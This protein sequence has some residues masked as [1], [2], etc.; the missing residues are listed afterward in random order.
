VRDQSPDSPGALLA[1]ERSHAELSALYGALAAAIGEAWCVIEVIFESGRP[2]DYLFIDVNAAFEQQTGLVDPVGRRM[3]ELAATHE[4]HWFEIYGNVVTS[5]QPARVTQY[6][7]ALQRWF[8]VRAFRAGAAEDRRV[9]VVFTDVTARKNAEAA[10]EVELSGARALQRISTK[11]I[12]EQRSDT[13][14]AGILDAGIELMRAD[15]AAIRIFDPVA[16]T[17]KL[18]AGR[19]LHPDSARRLGSVDAGPDTLAG[20]ALAANRRIVVADV[21]QDARV[22]AAGVLAEYQRSGLRS[23]QA[24][25]LI[26]RSGR[27]LGM[28]S[29]Y[30]SRV[31]APSEHEL[32]LFDVLA[33][34]VSDLLERTQAEAALRE[35]EERFRRLVHA[36]SQAVWEADADGVVIADSPSWRAYT[37]QSLEDWLGFGWLDAIH[38]DDR[39]FVEAQWRAAVAERRE[40]DLAFRLRRAD[41]EWRWTNLRAA[42]LNAPGGGVQKWVGMNIDVHARRQA[43]ADLVESDL[44]LRLAL[45][46]AEMGT[47]VWYPQDDVCEGDARMMALFGL[48]PDGEINLR[49]ALAK[50]IHVDD[51]ERYAEAV[52]RATDP[53]GDG[54]LKEDIRVLLGDG[55]VRWLAVKGRVQFGG[56]PRQALRMGGAAIDITHRKHVEA[57]LRD[58][59]ARLASALAATRVDV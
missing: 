37:G 54:V 15:A 44:R 55:G 32:G 57:A 24:T 49:L 53:G 52:L 48:P 43:E 6:A 36:T 35:S 9:A 4:A 5:G 2:V 27:A 1:G 46:A 26:A 39:T 33:R 11:L 31:H 34:Q 29:T 47:F 56:T 40:V 30:W 22:A 50:L 42:P 25:P 58:S 41:G 16:R 12:P 20:A 51:R 19:N 3:R 10:L 13:L 38:A 18:I 45:D 59:E 7:R 28:M 23:L 21:E 17:L 8:D 14:Y